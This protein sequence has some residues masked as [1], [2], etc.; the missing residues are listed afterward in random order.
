MTQL[1]DKIKE[2]H[3]KALYQPVTGLEGFDHHKHTNK[4]KYRID[5]IKSL[6]FHG[7]PYEVSVLDIGSNIGFNSFELSRLGCDVVG[8]ECKLLQYQVC[9]L[10]KEAYKSSAMFYHAKIE[11]YI[12]E[13]MFDYSLLLMIFHHMLKEGVEQALNT[14]SRIHKITK[15]NIILQMIIRDLEWLPL[16]DIDD[17]PKFL[18]NNTTLKSYTEIGDREK[19]PFGC[20]LYVFE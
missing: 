10:L 2:M 20:P 9:I 6:I 11:N 13:R 3:P 12:P 8:I 17:I 18:M 1:S 15:N 16:K 7:S 5:V 19:M 4:F 14:L